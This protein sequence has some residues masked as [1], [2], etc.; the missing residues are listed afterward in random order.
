[1]FRVRYYHPNFL[2]V[3]FRGV[4]SVLDASHVPIA[5]SVRLWAEGRVA[6]GCQALCCSHKSTIQEV[7]HKSCARF[8][9]GGPRLFPR[10]RFLARL[11]G[12]DRLSRSALQPQVYTKG[13]V[14]QTLHVL[15]V[16]WSKTPFSC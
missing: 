2:P 16:R 6:I 8:A 14:A 9:S 7:L 5:V 3:I 11:L 4:R 15:P 10:A 13:C 12:E 1:M